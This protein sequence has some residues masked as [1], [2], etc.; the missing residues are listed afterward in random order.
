[1][2]Q[3]LKPRVRRSPE[4]ARQVFLA[5]A[6]DILVE[7]GLAAVQMRAVARRA[8]VTDAAIAHHFGNREGLLKALM[9][10]VVT[11]VRRAIRA[12]TDRWSATPD[13]FRDLLAD[14]DTLYAQGYAE[15]AHAMTHSGW[16]DTGPPLLKP[17]MDALIK[18]NTHPQTEADDIR[19]VMAALHMDLALYP[20]YGAAFRRSVGLRSRKERAK[21]LDWWAASVEQMLKAP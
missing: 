14:L 8:D 5:C 12:I 7:D 16:R 11:K 15:L 18:Q 2:P 10:H 20:L 6:E 9:D 4:D 17:V 1:M 19:R 13:S 3:T 21:Q